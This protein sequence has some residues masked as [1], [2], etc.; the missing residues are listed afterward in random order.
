MMLAA[1]ALAASVPTES[2]KAYMERLYASYRSRNFNPLDHPDRYFTPRLVAAIREDA[3]LAKGEVGY[4]DGDPICQCQDPAGLHAKV[5]SVT[6]Q[7]PTT[8]LANVVV[9]FT[10]S[11]A[12]RVRFS[13]VQTTAG[14]RI[15]DVSSPDD[16]SFLHS[17]EA[18]NRKVQAKH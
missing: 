2:P 6:R 18:S 16:R 17:I 9:D 14:W 1:L 10:D 12:R 15:A 3:R 13:L 4:V 5:V 7:S 11:T 8:A